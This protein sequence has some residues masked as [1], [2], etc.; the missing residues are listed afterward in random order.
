MV[1]KLLIVTSACLMVTGEVS[2]SEFDELTKLTNQFVA[3]RNKSADEPLADKLSNLNAGY[4]RAIEKAINEARAKG[5]LD[6]VVDLRAETERVTGTEQE[7]PEYKSEAADVLAKTY[8]SHYD[9]I[10]LEDK[11]I[12]LDLA[13]K[14][15][16]A[17]DNLQGELTKQNRIDDA[18]EVKGFTDSDRF[19]GLVMGDLKLPKGVKLQSYLSTNFSSSEKDVPTMSSERDSTDTRVV[20]VPEN[21][22]LPVPPSFSAIGAA[23]MKDIIFVGRSVFPNVGMIRRDGALLWWGAG[24]VEPSIYEGKHTFCIDGALV[25]FVGLKEDGTL[26]ISDDADSTFS[27]AL[28]SWAG[29]TDLIAT[30]GIVVGVQSSGAMLAAGE[31]TSML[32]DTIHYSDVKQVNFAGAAGVSVLHQDG[33]VTDIS[34][35]IISKATT[36]GDIVELYRARLGLND[37]GEVVSWAGAMKSHLEEAGRFPK[38]VISD[39]NAFAAIREDGSFLAMK[40]DSDGEWDNLS[41]IEEALEGALSASWLIRGENRWILAILPADSVPRSGVWNAQE[42]S[43]ARSGLPR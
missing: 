41:D 43:T 13:S 39:E 25:P 19:Y 33:S 40:A 15:R 9:Q 22:N 38:H 35:Q 30:N 12:R 21:P 8:Y 11:G 6:A 42:L 17:L 32:S 29:V 3:A 7:R 24:Q 10:H 20:I 34:S 28:G 4:L 5:N 36:D 16:G 26:T 23:D 2:S 14:L 27:A 1:K 37:D 18:L 31:N